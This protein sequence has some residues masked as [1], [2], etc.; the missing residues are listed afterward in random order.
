MEDFS[1]TFETSSPRPSTYTDTNTPLDCYRDEWKV[2]IVDKIWAGYKVF[3]ILP[4]Q[5]E[6]KEGRAISEALA[7][8]L[9]NEYGP[10]G[11]TTRAG[12][13]KQ[14]LVLKGNETNVDADDVEAIFRALNRKNKKSARKE[15][16]MLREAKRRGS[17]FNHPVYTNQNLD[18]LWRYWGG[19]NWDVEGPEKPLDADVLGMVE[20]RLISKGVVWEEADDTPSKS[21]PLVHPAD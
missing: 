10:S 3:P 18:N 19:E 2:Y 6:R 4:N 21:G 15:N 8:A 17:Y 13:H 11:A 16:F 9:N 14:F 1:I 20:A 5:A 12:P 7:V